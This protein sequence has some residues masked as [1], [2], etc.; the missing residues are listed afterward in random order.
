MGSQ[1][2][3]IKVILFQLRDTEEVKQIDYASFLRA[4]KLSPA[5]LVAHDVVVSAP[6]VS[7]LEGVSALIIGGAKYSV[8]D[9]FP[10]FAELIEV[11]KVAREKKIPILGVCFGA[12]F[13]A[14]NFGGEVIHDTPKQEYGTFEMQGSEEAWTDML[15]ADA[16][17]RFLVQCAHHDRIIK[18]PPAAVVLASSSRCPIQAFTIPGNNVYGM[19]FH[20]ERNKADF[21]RLLE[22]YGAEFS[23]GET[24]LESVRSSLKETPDAESLV[25]KFIDRIVVQK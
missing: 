13:L 16:P 15:F 17:D 25:T 23:S 22:I 20:P 21:E 5:Q 8:L 10:H 14:H 6:D 24:T 11:V 18:L 7:I 12:Q 3:R 9:T 2:D 19:Q 4:T 1:R